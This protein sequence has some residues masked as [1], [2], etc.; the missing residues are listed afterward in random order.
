MATASPVGTSA[1]PPAG[2]SDGVLPGA[3]VEPGVAGVGV[4]RQRQVGIEAD[5]GHREHGARAYVPPATALVRVAATTR[6]S[7]SS[8]ARHE[9][10]SVQPAAS[11]AGVSA[12]NRRARR[13]LG[14]D[15]GIRSGTAA[16]RRRAGP[17]DRRLAGCRMRC[18]SSSPGRRSPPASVD[19]G[20]ARATSR[21]AAPQPARAGDQR[22]RGAAAHQPRAGARWRST[23]R[24]AALNLEL[25]LAHRRARLAPAP[26]SADCSPG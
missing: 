2:A 14:G 26:P 3:Q 22:H 6:R 10:H 8:A 15:G 1:R 7:A 11:A 18:A 20:T 19:R 13:T 12:R 25:D 21:R 5:D 16:E 17:V 4:R 23:I 24:R 9:R